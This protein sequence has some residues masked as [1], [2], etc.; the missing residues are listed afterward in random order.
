MDAEIIYIGSYNNT[1]DL[2]L[3]SDGVPISTSSVTRI[4]ANINGIDVSSTNQ[5]SDLIIWDQLGY[6]EGEVRCRLGPVSG[7]EPYF[8]DMYL[9]VFDPTNPDGVI[10]GP[11]TVKAVLLP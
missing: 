6:A 10:F 7:L 3:E 9:V 5:G 1:I 4:D 8:G 2:R 11:I